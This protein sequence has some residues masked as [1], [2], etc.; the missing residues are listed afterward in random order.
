MDLLNQ[1]AVGSWHTHDNLSLYWHP[2]YIQSHMHLDPNTT[3]T[4]LLEQLTW[5]QGEVTVYGK[6]HLEPRLSTYYADPHTNHSY[7]GKRLEAQP[8]HPLLLI[9]KNTLE[10]TLD[11][12]FNAVL[13]NYYRNGND[14]MGW[15]SDDEPELGA[16]PTIA[17]VSLGSPRQFNLR[18]KQDKTQKMAF[19]LGGGDL[20][21]MTGKTQRYWQHNITKTTQAIEGRINLTF[22]H[23]QPRI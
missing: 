1:H 19:N 22:R 4:Q 21:V 6:K 5:R 13:C 20:L 23:I 17:S 15:H 9:I 7:S 18:N 11:T 16:T 8:W 10:A 3:Y 2:D 12:H 14:G